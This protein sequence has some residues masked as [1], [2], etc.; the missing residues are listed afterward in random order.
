[1]S[2][3]LAQLARE[4]GIELLFDDRL[5][6]GLKAKPIHGEL[7]I[8]EALNQLLGGSGLGYRTGADGVIVLF[9]APTPSAPE[10]GVGAIAEILV[11]G[12]RTQ[13]VDIPRS[14]N[15][16]QPYK[17]ATAEDIAT[18][19][20]DDI[21]DYLRSREPA[22]TQVRPP[23]QDPTQFGSTRS[24]IDLRGFGSQ[25]TLVLIDGQRMPSVPSFAGEFN[26]SD[27]ERECP[28]ARSTVSRFSPRR[29]AASMD[30]APSA[31]SS[32]RC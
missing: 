26:Q 20:R 23:A 2:K 6:E 30:P 28:S 14:E 19:H 17:V 5:V 16:I 27:S 10:A 25:E 11:V 1:M 21:D 15:D 24:A 8:K 22:D 12:R 29:Q 13:N 3:A 31:A 9:A 18:A 32:T 7:S 4:A